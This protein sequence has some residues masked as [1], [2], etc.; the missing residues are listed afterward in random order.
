MCC[1]M[2][3][4]YLQTNPHSPFVPSALLVESWPK[5]GPKLPGKALTEPT[6]YPISHPYSMVKN[7][8]ITLKKCNNIY[9]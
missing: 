7:I 1:Q 2:F 5:V 6:S 9:P 3:L 4:L 8:C